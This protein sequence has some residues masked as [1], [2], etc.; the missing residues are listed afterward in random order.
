MTVLISPA[1]KALQTPFQTYLLKQN[2][3]LLVCNKENINK[4][5]KQI[6]SREASLITVVITT[7][8]K[9]MCSRTIEERKVKDP[10][11]G[12]TRVMITRETTVQLH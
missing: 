7:S 10:D 2:I 6:S 4:N 8:I 9:N 12:I 1:Q 5:Y 3:S 11:L